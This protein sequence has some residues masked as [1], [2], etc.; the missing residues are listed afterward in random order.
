M[1]LLSASVAGAPA[2]NV[3]LPSELADLELCSVVWST[4]DY[5]PRPLGRHLVLR[6]ANRW[7]ADH[8]AVRFLGSPCIWAVAGLLSGILQ[9]GC[10]Q[11]EL[12]RSGPNAIRV[13]PFSRLAWIP[14]LA[15]TTATPNWPC[16]ESVLRQPID[17]ERAYLRGVRTAGD[18]RLIG[19]VSRVFGPLISAASPAQR[20]W[21][22]GGTAATTPK[23]E[24]GARRRGRHSQVGRAF[25]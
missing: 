9:A 13:C 10:G 6:P 16:V 7:A 22:S 21:R 15:A 14:S 17:T 8:S 23:L 11:I 2:A 4:R 5:P 20:L 3:K 1:A 24:C 25:A 18:H 19:V 12:L